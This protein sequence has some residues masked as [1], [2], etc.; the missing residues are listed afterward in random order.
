MHL[1]NQI[2][3]KLVFLLASKVRDEVDVNIFPIDICIEIE[4][5]NL[6]KRLAAIECR[7]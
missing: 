1:R 7:S 3:N 2:V 6:E 4:E 5:I